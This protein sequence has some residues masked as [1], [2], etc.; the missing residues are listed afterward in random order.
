[1]CF[2]EFFV[3]IGALPFQRINKQRYDGKIPIPILTSAT[4]TETLAKAISCVHLLKVA[5]YRAVPS[6]LND[7][8]TRPRYKRAPTNTLASHPS[9]GRQHTEKTT[10][11]DIHPP[12]PLSE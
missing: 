4:F 2:A 1:M 3:V 10:A 6:A 9:V 11:D 12:P 5:R 8:L 7:G